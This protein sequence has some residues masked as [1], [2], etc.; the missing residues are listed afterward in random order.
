MNIQTFTS[1]FISYINLERLPFRSSNVPPWWC[2]CIFRVC[3]CFFS[4]LLRIVGLIVLVSWS[5]ARWR[6]S[7]M[8]G[9]IFEFVVVFVV[10]THLRSSAWCTVETCRMGSDKS[11][12]VCIEIKPNRGKLLQCVCTRLSTSTPHE[13]HTHVSV[14]QPF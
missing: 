14:C 2:P 8:S 13:Y 11:N 7:I 5:T 3:S 6:F 12:K 4:L 10:V 1:A 9:K